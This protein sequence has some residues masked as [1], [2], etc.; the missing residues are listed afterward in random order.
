[1]SMLSSLNSQGKTVIFI[2][3]SLHLVAEYARRV[4]AFVD[5]GIVYDGPVRAF[6]EPQNRELLAQAG[7]VPPKI[8]EL[9][10]RFG[11]TALSI[12]EFASLFD[13]RG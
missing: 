3:H 8:V 7:L 2:T 5:G 4:I 11:M 10:H 1:M 9:S 12:S 13:K 6:F